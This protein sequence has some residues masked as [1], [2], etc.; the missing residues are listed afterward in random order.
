LEE[1]KQFPQAKYKFIHTLGEKD[2]RTCICLIKS[3]D[4]Y[5]MGKASCSKKD[6]YEK[7]KGRLVALGRAYH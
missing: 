7:S 1:L 4:K 6:L 3:E 5:Y 2:R